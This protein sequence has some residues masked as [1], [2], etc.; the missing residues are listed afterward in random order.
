MNDKPN[1]LAHGGDL[2]DPPVVSE[3]PIP[4]FPSPPRAPSPTRNT[5]S[6]SRMV[7]AACTL[8]VVAAGLVFLTVLVIL[9]WKQPD[10]TEYPLLLPLVGAGVV[11]GTLLAIIGLVAGIIDL[12]QSR[13]RR[14]VS[15]LAV[16]VNGVA[17]LAV[18]AM[19]VATM[20]NVQ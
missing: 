2:Q 8:M 5:T 13:D 9:A 19:F 1:R 16:F 7:A 11:S 10:L 14:G 15:V 3:I 20:V 12:L 17:C 4:D 6:I 18:F